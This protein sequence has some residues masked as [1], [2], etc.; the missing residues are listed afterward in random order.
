VHFLGCFGAVGLRPTEHPCDEIQN[1]LGNP[2]PAR[3]TEIGRAATGGLHRITR[4]KHDVGFL[5]GTKQD[6]CA[7]RSTNGSK[8]RAI[9]I[10]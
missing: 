9:G 6:R 10:F 5:L 2:R 1:E 4:L 3:S 7:L 8:L